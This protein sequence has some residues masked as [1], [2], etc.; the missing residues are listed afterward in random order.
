MTRPVDLNAD[1]G[2]GYG[3]WSLG[4][5]V[6]L[7]DVITSA[8]VACGYHAGDPATMRRTCAAAVERGVAIG[9]QVSYPDLMGFG[10]RFLDME[11]GDL[12]DAVVYQVGA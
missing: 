6:G 2:E 10:R 12:A 7:L 8:N 1:L 9:A 4:D 3:R 5:D 11:P